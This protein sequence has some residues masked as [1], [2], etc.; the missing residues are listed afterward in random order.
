MERLNS[1]VKRQHGAENFAD[2]SEI[3]V[4]D[5][6]AQLQQLLIEN[7]RGVERGEDVFCRDGRFAIVKFYDDAR[8]ALL[9]KWDQHA[10]ATT[11]AASQGHGR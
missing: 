6:T 9:A 5:P 7:G 8:H 10:A 11:G 1:A 2:R 3:V 4:G